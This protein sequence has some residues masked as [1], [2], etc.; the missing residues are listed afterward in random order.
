MN[1]KF[2]EGIEKGVEQ[3]AVRCLESERIVEE[4]TAITGLSIEQ[5]EQIKKKYNLN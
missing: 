5:V 3:V 2:E 4:T 1:T